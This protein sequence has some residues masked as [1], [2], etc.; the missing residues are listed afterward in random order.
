VTGARFTAGEKWRLVEDVHELRVM[1]EG[2]RC[3]ARANRHAYA[4]WHKT[5]A[6]VC[7]LRDWRAK[8]MRPSPRTP[9]SARS[10]T[11]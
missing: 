9:A 7:E 5:V 2:G 3:V 4:S 6:D 1:T 11:R 8:G 10:S